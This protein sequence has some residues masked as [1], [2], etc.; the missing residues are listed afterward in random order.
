MSCLPA[1]TCQGMEPQVAQ[2]K[3]GAWLQQSERCDSRNQVETFLRDER[4]RSETHS[5]YREPL[6]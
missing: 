5:P 4:A 6:S 2:P 1:A 3:A